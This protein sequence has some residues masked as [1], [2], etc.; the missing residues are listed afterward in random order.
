MVNLIYV[1][2]DGVLSDF[3][4]RYTE[5]F[6]VSAKEVRETRNKK[7]YSENWHA[8]VTDKEFENLDWFRDAKL[9]FDY[10][11]ALPARKCILSSTG[12]ERYYTEISEQKEKWLKNHNINW[13][14]L[15]VPGRKYKKDYASPDRLLIDDVMDNV[16]SFSNKGGYSILHKDL[17]QTISLVEIYTKIML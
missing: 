5:K 12:G 8:F 11:E 14:T 1:D 2:M 6:S 3:E 15:F 9:L 7:E 4:K 16:D 17:N 10:L 13:D